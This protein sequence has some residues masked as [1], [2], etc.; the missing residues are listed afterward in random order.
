MTPST[1][2]YGQLGWSSVEKRLMYKTA[3]LTYKVLKNL[4]PSYVA[5]LLTPLF[6]ILSLKAVEFI[7]EFCKKKQ[8]P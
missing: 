4:T 2:M 8:A 7:T 6:F 3:L 5:S 1:L